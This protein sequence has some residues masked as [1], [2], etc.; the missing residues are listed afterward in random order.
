MATDLTPRSQLTDQQV[1]SLEA[2]SRQYYLAPPGGL[3]PTLPN[4]YGGDT[5]RP[6]TAVS[7]VHAPPG[8]DPN[9]LDLRFTT[10][11]YR[12]APLPGELLGG[13]GSTDT[14]RDLRGGTSPRG[15]LEDRFRQMQANELSQLREELGWQDRQ[16][17]K[18]FARQARDIAESF[19]D[20]IGK[21]NAEIGDAKEE[22]STVEESYRIFMDSIMPGFADAVDKAKRAAK[23]TAAIEAT[24]TGAQE[25]V[26][27][28]YAS[29]SGR[30]RALADAVGGSGNQSIANAINETVFEMKTFIDQQ[31]TLD[32]NQTITMHGIAAKMAAAAA[33]VE[34]ANARGDAAR[35]VYTTQGKYEKILTNLV[36]QRSL[37]NAQRKRAE[38][39][40]AEAR[41]DY[42]ANSRRALSKNEQR[43]R[44]SIDT[45]LLAANVDN[46]SF[47]QV[48][49]ALAIQRFNEDP[50]TRVDP[51]LNDHMVELSIAMQEAGYSDFGAFMADDRFVAPVGLHG[52]RDDPRVP[53]EELVPFSK[54][55]DQLEVM[56]KHAQAADDDWTNEM[57]AQPSSL[58][59]Q[60]G[61]A[62]R[63]GEALGLSDSSADEYAVDE[64][65]ARGNFS[66]S[67][68][69]RAR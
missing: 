40:L 44:D 64:V 62:Y 35:T 20:R 41:A 66:T 14:T 18:G 46:Y 5:H 12:S 58:Y 52:G 3:T 37:L 51:K 6:G 67:R 9:S 53:R 31:I 1:A 39:D 13:F 63:L 10:E 48:A 42:Q 17:E 36:R 23:A 56:A 8:V 16:A 65:F 15:A 28:V 43:I 7:P 54:Y 68:G 55:D 34:H 22:L 61:Q 45:E 30:V 11:D 60:Y 25:D 29:A 2:E 50:S 38:R 21:V 24:F 57:S 47:K 19:G 59:G 69:G 33:Q 4:F 26:D 27:D 32:R 49:G